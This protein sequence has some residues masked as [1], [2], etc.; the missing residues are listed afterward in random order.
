MKKDFLF[1][2]A[3]RVPGWILT[4]LFGAAGLAWSIDFVVWY[5]PD[6]KMQQVSDL[7]G[8]WIDEVIVIG[9]MA[10]LLLVAFSRERDEDEYTTRL[11]L[12]RSCGPYWPTVFSC[13]LRPVSC[14]N[15]PTFTLFS[16]AFSAARTVHRQIQDSG[17]AGETGGPE[18]RY[19]MFKAVERELKEMKTALKCRG[20]CTT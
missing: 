20:P 12:R 14:M 16:C 13:F 10:G 4:A 11:R 6:G 18:D 2:H 5:T 8:G 7:L 17:M 19:L 1:P 9:L 3:W 15:S